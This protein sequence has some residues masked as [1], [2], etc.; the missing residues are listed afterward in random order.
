MSGTLTGGK[1]KIVRNTFQPL[2][3]YAVSSFIIQRRYEH[4][5]DSQIPNGE[6]MIKGFILHLDGNV[7]EKEWSMFPLLEDMQEIVGGYIERVVISNSYIADELKDHFDPCGSSEIIVNEEGLLL[8]LE[9]NESAL[10]LTGQRF[11]G[12]VL[13]F[14]GTPMD[15][16]NG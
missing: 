9:L 16:L 1:I 7:E 11:V 14:V 3:T 5:H 4:S 13:L 12:P 10:M 6:K 2:C 15:E 8:N